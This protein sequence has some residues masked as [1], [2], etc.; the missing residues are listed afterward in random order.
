MLEGKVIWITRP[1]GQAEHLALSLEKSGARV[2][3]LP[4][5]IIE[6]LSTDEKIKN[7]VVNLD[8]Y[9]LLFFISTN[10]ATLGMEL[11]QAYWSQFPQIKIYAVGSATAE[12]ISNYD[13][14]AEFPGEQ[15]NSEALLALES[16]V[17]VE[18]K[19]ALIV[20]GVS[21]REL[22]ATGLREKGAIVDYLELYRRSCP[23]YDTGELAKNFSEATPSGIVVS[24]AEA[25][26]NL[27]DLLIKDG[28]KAESVPLFVSSRRIA[29]I[30]REAGF[31]LTIIMSGPDDKAII[32]SLSEKLS[33]SAP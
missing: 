12:I 19:K 22:L 17:D 9:D 25:L 18:G 4:M 14:N 32:Q 16:L 23:A 5:L 6:S 30:A 26:S 15:M 13:L 21:G 3:L 28:L 29:D 1:E 8:H 33:H 27:A 7:T 31:V 2:K 20:R 24:S 10:A 11:I